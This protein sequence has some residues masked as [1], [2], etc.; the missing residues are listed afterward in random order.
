MNIAISN[1]RYADRS[2]NNID[3]DVAGFIPSESIPFTYSPNDSSPLSIIVRGMLEGG[4]YEIAEYKEPLL[5][6]SG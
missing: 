5:T 2:N 3:M 6:Q 4:Q 1:L